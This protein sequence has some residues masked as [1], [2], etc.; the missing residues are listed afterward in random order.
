MKKCDTI[1]GLNYPLLSN[2]EQKCGTVRSDR[3]LLS[4]V[5]KSHQST[6]PRCCV[7]IYLLQ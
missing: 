6:S 1:V 3:L 5:C 7:F 2:A 4:R